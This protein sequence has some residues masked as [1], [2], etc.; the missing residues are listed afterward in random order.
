MLSRILVCL[1]FGSLAA[2]NL[3]S[4]SEELSFQKHPFS[5]FDLAD[6][7]SADVSLADF[8][9]DGDMDV[10][11]ANGRHWAQQDFVFLNAGN[12]RVLEGL[13][14][15]SRLGASYTV[16]V[17]D[18]DK[19]GFVDAVVVRDILPSLVFRNQG[20]SGFELMGE[21][22][23][24]AG[25]ARAA[26]LFDA[27]SDGNLDLAIA[28][29]RG[30]D[31]LFLGDGKGGFGAKI[32]LPGDGMGSTGIAVGDVNLD[33]HL[34]ILLARR[35][36][37][38]SAVLLGSGDGTFQFNELPGTEGDHRKGLIVDLNADAKP[39]IVLISTSGRHSII[40]W[41]E[42]DGPSLA[43]SFGQGG[44]TAQAV[45]AGDIDNDGDTDLVV[46]ADGD[47]VLYFNEGALEFKREVISGDSDT[48]G[49]AISDMNGDGLL[50][51]VFANSGSPNEI[52]RARHR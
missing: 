2:M 48:Y 12:G 18:L 38:P 27:D 21:I 52:V 25:Q 40:S 29:R 22:P 49:V 45:A 19:D 51:I 50:D 47:D 31:M 36:G 37:A 13:P 46:G 6:H 43:S 17:G 3:T 24:S 15:G 10:F 5:L 33:G 35:D 42:S 14:I 28:T 41:A 30:S 32:T 7:L 9:A 20:G 16:Q 8:D 39:E 23:Q 44:E 11:V 4:Q 34:D 26:S 1:L